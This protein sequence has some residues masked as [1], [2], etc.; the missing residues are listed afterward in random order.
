MKF[1]V[2]DVES[3]GLMGEPFAFGYV[4]LDSNNGMIVKGDRVSMNPADAIGT[5]GGHTWVAENCPEMLP[6]VANREAL[7]NS[8]RSAYSLWK[9][10]IDYFA[11]DCPFPVETNFLAKVFPSGGGP[12]PLIDISSVLLAK[13]LNPL[14]EYERIGSHELPRHDPLADSYQSARLLR[15][16]L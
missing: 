6:W 1:F 2:F 8:F 13:G 11:A 12:Y 10:H 16:A 9:P 5:I 7:Y 14:K 4:I 15:E 3:V